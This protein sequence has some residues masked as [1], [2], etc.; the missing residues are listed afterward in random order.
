MTWHADQTEGRPVGDARDQLL[1]KRAGLVTQ[2]EQ[3]SLQPLRSKTQSAA[4]GRLEDLTNL[5]KKIKVIDKKLGRN[6]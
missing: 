6:V 1:A 4:I 3:L 5:A 2:V